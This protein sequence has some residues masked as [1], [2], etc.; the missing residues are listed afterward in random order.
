V[1]TRHAHVILL[2]GRGLEIVRRLWAARRLD[3]PFLL[4]G[5]DCPRQDAERPCLGSV[6]KAWASAC[7]AAGFPV[8]RKHGGYTF[9]HTRNSAATNLRAGGMDEADAMK[10]TGHTTTHVFR[11]YD[12]GNVDALRER[13]TRARTAVAAR[14]SRSKVVPMEGRR[15][16]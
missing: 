6:K 8:G 5:E 11:H 1:K 3:C 9:H 4:H 2:E 7:K 15:S 16:A 14:P 10:I 12:I 13:L